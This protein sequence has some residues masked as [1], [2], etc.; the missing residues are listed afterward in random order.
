MRIRKRRPT[1]AQLGLTAE[2][3][4]VLRALTTPQH[5]Q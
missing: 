1:P 3:G 5:I 2:E 4:R